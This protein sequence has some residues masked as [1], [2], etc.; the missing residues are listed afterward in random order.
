MLSQLLRLTLWLKK[1]KNKLFWGCQFHVQ[2][3]ILIKY[4]KEYMAKYFFDSYLPIYSAYEQDR[5]SVFQQF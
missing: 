3:I 5:E 4:L 1:D 2:F